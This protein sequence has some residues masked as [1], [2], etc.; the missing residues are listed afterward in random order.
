MHELLDLLVGEP[1]PAE[2]P[3]VAWPKLEGTCPPKG[4]GPFR[5]TYLPRP[6]LDILRACFLPNERE[7]RASGLSP[8]RSKT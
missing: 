1:G 5:R 8:H 2:C 6:C 3:G 4:S 7:E